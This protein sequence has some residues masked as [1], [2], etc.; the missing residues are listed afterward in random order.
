V[1][2]EAAPLH[3]AR[4]ALAK[5]LVVVDDQQLGALLHRLPLG[6]H[7]SLPS[8][9][10]RNQR[11]VTLAPPAGRLANSTLAPVRSSS[12]QAIKTPSPIWSP[13]AERVDR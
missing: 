1:H 8:R 11:T 6:A 9:P 13:S 2:D 10:A 7:D 12:V 5:R 3:R 4:Q